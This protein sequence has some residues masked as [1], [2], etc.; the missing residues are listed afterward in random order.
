MMP[1][2]L[3]KHTVAHCFRVQRTS[4]LTA[5]SHVLMVASLLLRRN[6]SCFPGLGAL[7][8]IKREPPCPGRCP[9]EHA[10]TLL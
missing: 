5:G 7:R 3:T 2:L 10:S 1:L 9:G 8:N 6:L 4:T